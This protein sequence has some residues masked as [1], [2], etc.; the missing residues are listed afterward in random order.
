[1][2]RR[3]CGSLEQ[4]VDRAAVFDPSCV[5]GLSEEL[6]VNLTTYESPSIVRHYSRLQHLFPAEQTIFDLVRTVHPDPDMLDI[7]VG[8]GRT[9]LNLAPECR[10]YVGLDY[11]E[12][13]VAEGRKACDNRYSIIHADARDMHQIGGESCD[14]VLF[15]FNG[16]DYVSHQDRLDILTEIR[17]VCR[18]GAFFAFSTHNIRAVKPYFDIQASSPKALV[19]SLLKHAL[20]FPVEAKLK[21]P[22]VILNDGAHR[23]RLRTYYISPEEQVEQL[24][25]A[26][27]GEVRAFGL[28][29]GTEIG[30]TDSEL[31]PYFLCVAH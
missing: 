31:F 18:P 20:N 9:T 24:K 26:G 29:S 19:K 23:F 12:A 6:Q 30:L 27:F 2:D 10:S 11:S 13:M 22:H 17:R 15:S 5:V 4:I 14:F 7:G 16:L 25:T 21:Q 28:N 1:L 3:A 8:T